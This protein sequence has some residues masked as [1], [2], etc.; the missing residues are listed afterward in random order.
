MEKF[1]ICLFVFFIFF[2]GEWFGG[3]LNLFYK[4]RWEGRLKWKGNVRD[5]NDSIFLYVY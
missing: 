3:M 2:I 1:L 5:C 4:Y